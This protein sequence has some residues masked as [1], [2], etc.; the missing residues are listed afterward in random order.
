MKK[1]LLHSTIILSLLSLLSACQKSRVDYINYLTPYQLQLLHTPAAGTTVV[2]DQNGVRTTTIVNAEDIN[3]TLTKEIKG[4]MFGGGEN[5]VKQYGNVN[6]TNG[7]QVK[8]EIRVSTADPAVASS[9]AEQYISVDQQYGY[10]M[11]FNN[12]L[13]TKTIN[14]ITYTNVILGIN[15]YRHDTLFWKKDIGILGWKNADQNYTA[16]R[17]F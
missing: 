10:A 14:G 3:S 11:E 8:I 1:L 6:Y 15:S 16:Y 2:F 4:G 9:E 7:S 17:V 12:K 13:P 5:Y